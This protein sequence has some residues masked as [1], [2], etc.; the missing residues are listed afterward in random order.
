MSDLA[1]FSMDQLQQQVERLSTEEGY[2][3]TRGANYD[4]VMRAF[5]EQSA[6]G[7]ITPWKP[8]AGAELFVPQLP[9]DLETPLFWATA[10]QGPSLSAGAPV[11][12]LGYMFEKDRE[13]REGESV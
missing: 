11:V 1:P 13:L 8:S 9:A 12:A 2:G 6:F 5:T 7:P 10:F 3:P 4:V